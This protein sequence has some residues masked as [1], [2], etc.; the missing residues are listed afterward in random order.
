MEEVE[1]QEEI[2]EEEIQE[3]TKL[4]LDEF[5]ENLKLCRDI[6]RTRIPCM[7]GN[8]CYGSTTKHFIDYTHPPEHP[9][10]DS[11]IEKYQECAYEFLL[12]GRKIYDSNNN[13]LHTKWYIII[14]KYLKESD[15]KK[16]DSLYFYILA[17]IACNIE[18]YKKRFGKYFLNAVL[19]G[20]EEHAVTGMFKVKHGTIVRKCL[21]KLGVGRERDGYYLSNT[22]LVNYLRG[23]KTK[24]K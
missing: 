18:F 6:E 4:L 14:Q 13:K 3:D 12:L 1:I 17:N 2:Q 23:N 20:M 15:Y 22:A 7:Y 8:E 16:H 5:E 9:F 11:D 10:Q 21:H 24:L 19:M